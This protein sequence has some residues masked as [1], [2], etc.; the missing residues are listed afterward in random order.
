MSGPFGPT[1]LSLA[2][3]GSWLWTDLSKTACPS[4]GSSA[5]RIGQ[6]SPAAGGVEPTRTL[7]AMNIYLIRMGG[8]RCA[9]SVGPTRPRL[10]RRCSPLDILLRATGRTSRK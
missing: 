7:M 2:L 10:Q 9:P 4:T 8:K 5:T 3:H 1:C 6:S